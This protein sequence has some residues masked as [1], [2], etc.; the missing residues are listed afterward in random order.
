MFYK[1]KGL[2]F[3]SQINESKEDAEKR[4]IEQIKFDQ[5]QKEDKI[6]KAESLAINFIENICSEKLMSAIIEFYKPENHR[7]VGSSPEFDDAVKQLIGHDLVYVTDFFVGKD[8]VTCALEKHYDNFM[9]GDIHFQ[10]VY[11]PKYLNHSFNHFHSMST[12]NK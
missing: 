7:V 6:K 8:K 10:L 12:L 4:A 11:N 9:L 1:S 5:K 3:E 2:Y